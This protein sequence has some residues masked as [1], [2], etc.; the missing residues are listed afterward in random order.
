MGR[1]HGLMRRWRGIAPLDRSEFTPVT[2]RPLDNLDGLTSANAGAP[3]GRDDGEIGSTGGLPPASWVKSYDEG[4]P[5][6]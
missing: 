4:R 6:K 2:E 3:G 5:R 1:L